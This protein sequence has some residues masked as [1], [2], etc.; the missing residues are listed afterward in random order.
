MS[1]RFSLDEPRL[2]GYTKPAV[3][4]PVRLQS[5]IF[6]SLFQVSVSVSIPLALFIGILCFYLTSIKTI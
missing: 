4:D 1:P 6:S 3:R 5:I 2:K